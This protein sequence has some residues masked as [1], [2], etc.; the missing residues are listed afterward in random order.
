M[1]IPKLRL[2]EEYGRPIKS[3][4]KRKLLPQ[5]D[6]EACEPI[7]PAHNTADKTDRPPHG[8]SKT[9]THANHQPTLPRRKGRETAAQD[10]T[11]DLRR[12]LD[13]RAGLARAIYES[14]AR[15][16]TQED[17]YQARRDQH[18]LPRGENRLGRPP[19]SVET[20]P[21]TEAPLTPY[22]SPMR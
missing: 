16:P 2:F 17:G 8:C 1:G 22:S 20:P 9:A 15:A 7:A 12:G 18:N 11:Y 19:N 21:V 6:I 10:Y 5:S 4:P 13:A 14:K 3:Y